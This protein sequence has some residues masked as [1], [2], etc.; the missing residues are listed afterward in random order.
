[1]FVGSYNLDP[2]STSLNCE[3]GVLVEDE[4]LARELEAI[5]TEQTDG[6][7]AWQVAIE[8]DGNLQWTDGSE[9]FDSDPK[10]TAGRK[11][12]AWIT[13]VLHLDAQL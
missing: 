1:M 6:Q 11:F 3:Q 9:A 2:R 13:R 8:D 5:F 12:Q 4:V 7:R 10:A